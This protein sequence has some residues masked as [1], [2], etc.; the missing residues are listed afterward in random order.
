MKDNLNM[1][2]KNKIKKDV[3]LKFFDTYI[4]VIQ[5]SVGTKMFRNIYAEINGKYTDITDNG[6]L[7]CAFY[8]SSVLLIFKSIGSVHSTVFS[9]IFDMKKSGWKETKKP[10]VGDVVVWGEEKN[11]KHKHI[12]FFLGDE[13]AIS[14]SKYKG[15]PIEHSLNMKDREID[16]FLTNK[17]LRKNNLNKY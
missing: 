4:K 9:T 14:N 8:V 3:N 13:K 5:N 12:G 7:S 17:E 6:D 1:K 16:I 15:Y 11:K 2:D 10:V